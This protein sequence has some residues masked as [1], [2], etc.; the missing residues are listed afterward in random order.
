[1]LVPAWAK[2]SQANDNVRAEWNRWSEALMTHE[3]GHYDLA[4]QYLDNFEGSLVGLPKDDAWA[5]F[6]QRKTDLQTASDAYDT[7]TSHGISQGTTL[8]TSIT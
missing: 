3:M 4:Y 6:E 7:S 8:D 1:V 2:L 5:A